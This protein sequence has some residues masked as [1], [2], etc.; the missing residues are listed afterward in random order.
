MSTVQLT[1]SNRFYS[2]ILIHTGNQKDDVSLSKEFQHHL[3]K[4]HR[5]NGVFDLKV[6]PHG[7]HIYAKSSD[8]AKAKICTYHQS[9]HELPHWKYV[10][11]FCAKCP[12]INMPDQETDHKY[13]YTTPSILFHIY[14]TIAL[15]TDLGRI[16]LIL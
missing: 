12:C 1:I 14:H 16:P 6:M 7:C 4:E 3:I 5:R 15:C 13:S 2:Q 10:L 8:I 11:W 9:D